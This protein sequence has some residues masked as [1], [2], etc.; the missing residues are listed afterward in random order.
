M[1]DTSSRQTAEKVVSTNKKNISTKLFVSSLALVALVGFTFGT[2]ADDLQLSSILQQNR[3]QADL[4]LSSVE[5]AYDVL[6]KQYD[7]SLD[8]AKLIEGAKRGL[9]EATGDPY[10]TYFSDE[11]AQSFL[12][13]VEGEFTGIGAELGR[14]DD[15]LQIVSTLDGSPAA[16]AGLLG[17]DIIVRVN[18]ED[19][20]SWSIERAV[21]TIRGEKGTTVKLSVLR[22]QELK[23]F[24]VVRET[25]TNPSVKSEINSNGI[26]VMRIS[27][28]GQTETFA[29]AKTAAENYKKSN[30]KGVVVDL[31]GNGGG[32][33]TTA[34]QIAGLWLENKVVV[35]QRRD[36][37]VI[38]TLK[39][40]SDAPLK[41][42]PTVVLI[43]GN[44]ASAS[45]ILAGAL[46]DNKA[47]RLVG[48]KTFGKGSVQAFEPVPGGGQLKVTVAK[49]Y[50][51]NGRNI[52]KE[53]IEPDQKVKISAEDISA[54]ADPQK[55][56]AI[57]ALQ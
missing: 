36:N 30:V 10:T 53:G 38:D 16:K 40:G 23:E 2:R 7:G 24:S 50:T 3:S 41:G 35:T 8:S 19:T 25:I 48:E 12:K 42:L 33:L 49:W 9:V 14:K 43:D 6:R 18:D 55:E 57:K 34:Q 17:N 29:L 22:N 37:K 28:F 31:R 32:Y 5:N 26:A 1:D 11:E 20:T 13:D 46:K 4:D 27:T 51:P 15:K 54:G 39:T 56:A 21:K 52:S 47:A 45:E 44:S